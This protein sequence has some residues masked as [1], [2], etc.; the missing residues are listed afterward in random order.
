MPV[1]RLRNQPPGPSATA[2]VSLLLYTLVI[3]YA[4]L[5]PFSGWRDLGIS[6]VNFL[7]NPLPYYWTAF[8]LWTNVAGYAP[9][10][11]L[12]VFSVYPT[13][14]GAAAWI[15]A[16]LAGVALSGTMEAVQTWLPNRVSSNLDLVANA[17]GTMVGALLG[18]MLT[19][20]FLQESRLLVLRRR[21]FT[22]EAGRGLIVV[23]L[24]PLAQLYPQ[25]YLF[26][27]GQFTPTLSE[28]L[29]DWFDADIDI[30][31]MFR[32]ARELTVEQYWLSEAM[33]TASGMTG[34][35]LTLLCLTRVRAPRVAL[36]LLLFG[37]ALIAKSLA[38]ALHFSPEN[39]FFWLTPGAEGGL[40]CGIVM[41]SGLIFAPP[42]AQRRVA[43]LTLLISLAVIN[44]APPNPYFVLTLQ[45][46]V[47]GKFLNFN[48]AAQFLSLLWPF[49]TL[50]FLLH[51]VHRRLRRRP[52]PT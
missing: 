30:G 1:V 46:W 16:A 49:V 19:R 43:A 24:W 12:V 39:A 45:A 25:G 31:A 27:L 17:V 8:D 47:Q 20:T 10:G 22:R 21:W 41:I 26:G 3:V 2:R 35:V 51:P 48:G 44:I 29:S 15:A 36:V 52:E 5:Y 9:F 7:F 32:H 34:A 33:I 11:L 28:W 38:S 40:L 50:W 6:P 23:A 42:V 4:S 13:L 37:A 14:R 18:V